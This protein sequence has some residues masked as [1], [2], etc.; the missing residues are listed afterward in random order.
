MPPRAAAASTRLQQQ[1][2]RRQ[3]PR[4]PL[5][6]LLAA[7]VLA[8]ELCGLQMAELCHSDTPSSGTTAGG[9]EKSAPTF[10]AELC[11]LS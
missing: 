5:S 11:A 8:G 10:L 4:Q 1:P 7:S 3:A 6:L 2:R 9:R